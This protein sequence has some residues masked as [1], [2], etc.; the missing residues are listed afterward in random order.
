MAMA[1]QHH[2]NSFDQF[3]KP[4]YP[5]TGDDTGFHK[6]DVRSTF[7][8]IQESRHWPNA[9]LA[10][11]EYVGPEM[12]NDPDT[13]HRSKVEQSIN[14]KVLSTKFQLISQK[15]IKEGQWDKTVVTCL[16]WHGPDNC[17]EPREQGLVLSNSLWYE[18]GTRQTIADYGVDEWNK[19]ATTIIER[20]HELEPDL[21]NTKCG[22]LIP[23]GKVSSAGPGTNAVFVEFEFPTN[24][25]P[26][27]ARWRFP[28]EG[29]VSNTHSRRSSAM[30]G[31]QD[32]SR[33]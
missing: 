8:D 30:S 1:E 21:F 13:I 2:P 11:Q 12:L 28:K 29:H 10:H 26:S 31:S 14:P 9:I 27:V 20:L 7:A 6:K 23:D 15:T 19:A 5:E 16:V 18:P 22:S 3:N 32:R 25:V 4:D 24:G 33:S 17:I